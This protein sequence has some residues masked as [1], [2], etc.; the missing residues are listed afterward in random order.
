MC[1]CGCVMSV[2]ICTSMWKPEIKIQ[3]LPLFH[4]TLFFNLVIFIG[5]LG[6]VWFILYMWRHA[7]H[8]VWREVRDQVYGTGSLFAPSCRSQELNSGYQTCIVSHQVPL[9]TEPSCQPLLIFETGFFTVSEARLFT[10]TGQWT[11][12]L[13]LSLAPLVLELQ[14]HGAVPDFLHWRWVP[15]SWVFVFDHKALYSL[16]HFSSPQVVDLFWFN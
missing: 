9:P 12:T 16:N 13:G 11:S 5:V 4:P 6:Y 7:C 1:L 2:R 10:S 3:H 14:A 15:Q 8:G